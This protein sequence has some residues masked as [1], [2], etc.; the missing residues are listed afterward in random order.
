MF[1]LADAASTFAIT[2]VGGAHDYVRAFQPRAVLETIARD[3]VTATL[4]VPTMITALLN[5][6]DLGRLDLSSLRT[7]VYG[8]SPIPADT[9]REAIAALP[10]DLVQGYG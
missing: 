2:F 8:A 9:L 7:L 5:H 1:H 6:R 3:R 4:L 10:C